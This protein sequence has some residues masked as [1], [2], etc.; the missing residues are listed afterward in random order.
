[1]EGG[2]LE[3]TAAVASGALQG[4]TLETT[5]VAG[6]ALETAL[7]SGALETAAVLGSGTGSKSNNSERRSL[8][9]WI[10]ERERRR[11]WVRWKIRFEMN[12]P[13]HGYAANI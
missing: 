11:S 8:H 13:M 4:G 1:L 9:C 12:T 6:G 5:A 3:T 7:E 2:A 10:E